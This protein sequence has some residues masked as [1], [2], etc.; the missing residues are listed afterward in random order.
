MN[1]VNLSLEQMMRFA[2]AVAA[3]ITAEDVNDLADEDAFNEE[4]D[5]ILD[6]T[7]TTL[8]D[9]EGEGSNVT[10]RS[11]YH[12]ENTGL[13]VLSDAQWVKG[14]PRVTAYIMKFDNGFATYAV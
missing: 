1:N 3:E 14:Q 11:R 13:T 8:S 10:Y 12:D 2:T 4:R 6:A 5:S 7:E 9:P